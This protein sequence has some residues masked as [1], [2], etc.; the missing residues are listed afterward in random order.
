MK[1][2]QLIF[3]GTRKM[4]LQK[5]PHTFGLGHENVLEDK[6]THT[7]VSAMQLEL[8]QWPTST[9]TETINAHFRAPAEI[10]RNVIP[11]DAQ[12]DCVD[13]F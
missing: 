11:E 2:V 10:Y 7:R 8:A 4:S 6:S 9:P 1:T 12:N 13:I 3:E 5:C